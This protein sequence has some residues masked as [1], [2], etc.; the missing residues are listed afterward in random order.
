LIAA[1]WLSS[2]QCLTGLEFR[3]RSTVLMNCGLNQEMLFPNCVDGFKPKAL[4][5]SPV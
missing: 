2:T 4:N 5:S 1:L 3:A